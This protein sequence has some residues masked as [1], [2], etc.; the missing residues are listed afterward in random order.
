VNDLTRGTRVRPLHMSETHAPSERPAPFGQLPGVIG[1]SF[2][3][4]F[5]GLAQGRVLV[6]R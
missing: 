2:A 5:A 6:P 3:P 4:F 1:P